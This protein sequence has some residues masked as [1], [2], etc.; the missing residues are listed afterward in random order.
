MST[1]Y[2]VY[3][4]IYLLINFI[5]IKNNEIII[6]FISRLSEIPKDLNSPK[7]FEALL[8]N[9]YYTYV[10]IGT[11]AQKMEFLVD[12]NNYDS[13][14]V[15]KN[16]YDNY[17]STTFNH[18]NKQ[19]NYYSN[20]YRLS[21][22]ASDVV[23]F[24]KN[25]S[26]FTL[27]FLHVISP[28]NE[29]YISYPG[30]LGFGISQLRNAH[31]KY[32]FM[33]QL[34]E[35]KL[36]KNFQYTLIFNDNDFNGKIILEK[37][38]YEDYPEDLLVF[39][40]SIFCSE[41]TYY[42]SWGWDYM[43]SYYNSMQ[44]EIKN[45]FLQPEIGL[46]IAREKIKKVFREQFFESKIKQNKCFE[47][48]YDNYFFYRCEKD[49]NIKEFGKVEF[50]IKLKDMN[51]TLDSNDL[52]YEYNNNLYFLMIFKNDIKIEDIFLGYPF[53]KKYNTFFNPEQRIVGFY[54][55]KIDYNPNENKNDK[56]NDDIIKNKNDIIKEKIEESKKIIR[57]GKNDM[58]IKA[59]ENIIFKIIFIIALLIGIFIILFAGFYLY[60]GIKRKNKGNYFEE[61]NPNIND[62]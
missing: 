4:I 33:D 26:N 22:L 9:K 30:I 18:I 45:V 32:S 29:P 41:F 20:D 34:K 52:F 25:I 10:D 15:H 17:S 49:V 38:I 43:F 57:N 14:V 39:D 13:F 36:I 27:T 55:L 48:Y 40:Y 31:F 16:K 53:F 2:Y 23:S 47:S 24:E 1:I 54:K 3:S 12:F 6:P 5:S 51:I 60:R 44:L 7:F 62:L 50:L 42:Y 19:I 59:D 21:Y 11:P 56:K 37:D 61:L 8:N 35:K 58:K 28:K 46:I